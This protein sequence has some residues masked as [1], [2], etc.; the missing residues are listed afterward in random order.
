MGA[1]VEG[2]VGSEEYSD[3]R[4]LVTRANLQRA[5]AHYLRGP[6]DSDYRPLAV[7]LLRGENGRIAESSRSRPRCSPLWISRRKPG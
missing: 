4:C 6:G 2:G 1:W 3:F 7:D 5:V